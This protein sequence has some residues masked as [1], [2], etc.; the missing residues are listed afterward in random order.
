MWRWPVKDPKGDPLLRTPQDWQL[1]SF[2][3]CLPDF[4]FETPATRLNTRME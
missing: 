4:Q 3:L 2:A 1:S